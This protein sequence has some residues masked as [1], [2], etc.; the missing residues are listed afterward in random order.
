MFHCW[1]GHIWR[2]GYKSGSL[3]CPLYPDVVPALQHWDARG[4]KVYIYSSGSR[5][6]QRDLFAHT[7]QGDVRRHLSGY[8]DTASGSKVCVHVQAA[9]I[10]ALSIGNSNAWLLSCPQLVI[11][12]QRH[13]SPVHSLSR[14]QPIQTEI[15]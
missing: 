4:V 12:V 11:A 15:V 5:L 13:A 1:Q 14:N 10:C 7:T 6:A 2:N 3:Q 8:F 9:N